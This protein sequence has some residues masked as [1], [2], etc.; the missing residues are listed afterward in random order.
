M[1]SYSIAACSP[2]RDTRSARMVWFKGLQCSGKLRMYVAR[3]C[4]AH[5]PTPACCAKPSKVAADICSTAIKL[6]IA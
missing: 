1:F 6:T 3:R 5:P 4:K 2:G